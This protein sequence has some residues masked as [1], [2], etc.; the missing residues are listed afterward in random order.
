MG[1]RLGR[2]VRG[3]SAA[4]YLFQLTIWWLGRRGAI[5]TETCH[6]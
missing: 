1:P 6:M 3:L 5:I 4:G 2:F